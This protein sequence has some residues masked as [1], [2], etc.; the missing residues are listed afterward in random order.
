MARIE[1]EALPASTRALAE[2]LAARVSPDVEATR[3]IE[4]EL[5]GGR[6]VALWRHDRFGATE[7][8]RF[9]PEAAEELV[10]ELLERVRSYEA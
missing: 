9:D 1:A 4:L 7:L 3:R 10:R 8:A 6:L 2:L 5:H